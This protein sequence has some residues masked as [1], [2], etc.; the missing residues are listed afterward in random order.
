MNKK[1][2]SVKI[3]KIRVFKLFLIIH[4]GFILFRLLLFRLLFL[5]WLI[6]AGMICCETSIFIDIDNDLILLENFL[7]LS[8]CWFCRN[9][10]EF[11]TN[12]EKYWRYW[13][14]SILTSYRNWKT[15]FSYLPLSIRVTNKLYFFMQKVVFL[16]CLSNK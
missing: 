11:L 13:S 5:R 15:K 14:F 1:K 12:I 2:V 8:S 10:N 6:R 9:N 3:K 4:F 7:L 16:V